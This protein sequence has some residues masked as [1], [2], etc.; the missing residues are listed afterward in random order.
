MFSVVFDS[1]FAKLTI[2]N[3]NCVLFIDS[4][5]ML[6]VAT[7]LYIR[8]K[9]LHCD[10]QFATPCLHFLRLDDLELHLKSIG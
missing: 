1:L 6:L 5:L 7:N 10:L 3:L 9:D 4:W 8:I 2:G